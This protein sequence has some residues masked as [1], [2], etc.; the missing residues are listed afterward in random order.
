VTAASIAGALAGK[1]MLVTGATGFVGTAIVER[2]LA[3]LPD[4]RLVLLIRGRGSR[5]AVRRARELLDEHAFGPLRER[6]GEAEL[7][8]VF[9]DPSRVE[10]IQA[11]F[12]VDDFVLPADLDIVVHC[13]ADTAFDRTIDLAFATN[14]MGCERLYAAVVASGSRPHLVHISTAY[15]AGLRRGP[16]LEERSVVDVSWQSEARAVAALR[17]VAEGESRQPPVLKVLWREAQAEQGQSNPSGSARAAEDARQDW[18]T[19]RLADAGRARARSLGYPDVYALTKALGEQAVES[20][21]REY[22]LPLSIVRPAITESALTRPYPG[23]I[24][25]FKMAEP[26]IHAYARGDLAESPAAPDSALDVMPIDFVVNAILA[27]SASPPTD[28][29]AYYHVVSGARNPLRFRRLYELGRTYFAEHPVHH[30]PQPHWTFPGVAAVER[31]LSLAELAVDVADGVLARVPRGSATTRRWADTLDVQRRRL[32][33]SRRL[34][35]L[36]GTYVSAE[37]TFLD[38]ATQRLYASLSES[39]QVTFDFDCRHIDWPHYLLKVHLPA[40]RRETHDARRV[41]APVPPR[42]SRKTTLAVFDLDGT[43]LQTT[44]I[45]EYLRARWRDLPRRRRISELLRIGTRLPSYVAAEHADRS[46]FLRLFYREYSGA[47]RVGLERLVDAELAPSVWRRLAT[48]GVR[49]IREH[50]TAGHRTV[51]L[52]G[53]LDVFTRPLAPLFDHVQATRLAVRDGVFTGDLDAPPLVGE[54]RLAW[55]KAF[56]AQESVDLEDVYVYADSHSDL[57]L[58]AGVGHPVA[59]N[60]DVRLYR[61]ARRRRWPVEEWR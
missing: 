49:R 29:P 6:W 17:D 26:I 19:R 18:V 37:M 7:V 35:D 39:D 60:P 38:D 40:V 27:A 5:S 42:A 58:L 16:I 46:Q 50:R 51:L 59:I 52:T 57:P 53:A 45:E 44:V 55:L 30:R 11:D 12:A 2:V 47:S 10:I 61:I 25:G 36:F 28:T 1:R 23:W 13:A 24:K 8:R 21:A 4:V 56:A 48:D 41:R 15:V 32:Q 22:R 31:R 43:L 54:A 33:T 9:S 14:V 20:I 34:F 3:S